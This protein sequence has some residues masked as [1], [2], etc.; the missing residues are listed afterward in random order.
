MNPGPSFFKLKF[1]AVARIIPIHVITPTEVMKA[2]KG[3]QFIIERY[4]MALELENNRG[5]LEIF[6]RLRSHG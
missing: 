3:Q 4:Q 6:N 1:Y 2:S 5:H